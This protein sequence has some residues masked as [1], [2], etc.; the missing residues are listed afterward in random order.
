M[1]SLGCDGVL[2]MPVH[3][4]STAPTELTPALGRSALMWLSVA[5]RP[6]RA[7]ELWV[8]FQIENA[9]DEGVA[10]SLLTGSAHV[11]DKE[12]V[13]SLRKL[14]G[15]LICIRQ[16]GTRA[17]ALY[18]GLNQRRVWSHKDEVAVRKPGPSA[19]FSIAQAHG[20]VARVCMAICGST[21][22][23][24]AHLSEDA[25][26]SLVFYAWN[27]WRAHLSL[28]G[29][30]IHEQDTT[31]FANRMVQSV[32]A[33]TLAVLLNLNDFAIGPIAFPAHCSRAICHSLVK[34]AQGVLEKPILLLAALIRQGHSF[35]NIRVVKEAFEELRDCGSTSAVS[36][37]RRNS[38]PASSQPRSTVDTLCLEGLL[39]RLKPLLGGG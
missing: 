21:T 27:H 14:L 16:D 30:T 36:T 33:D 3:L 6:L 24:P 39:A 38:M 23:P 32:C 25:A 10:E 15:G 7:H 26:S 20:L 18:V 8:A 31:G 12:A 1:G 17:G 35:Q 5:R 29:I 13:S 11:N 28:S 2:E 19:V 22:S 34:E 37:E 4:V 9:N